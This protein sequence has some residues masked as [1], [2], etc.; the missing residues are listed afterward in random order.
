MVKYGAYAL[1]A[2]LAIAVV[3]G[4]FPDLDDS[5]VRVALVVLGLVGGALNVGSGKSAEFL[6][7]GVALMLAA[8][9]K[10]EITGVFSGNLGKI[11]ESVLENVYIVTAAATLVL[12]V[13]VILSAAKSGG[14]A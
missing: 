12:A 8:S 5:W 13:K 6:M 3:V 9:V 4:I 2:G 14:K 1:L 10:G 7:A 11:I